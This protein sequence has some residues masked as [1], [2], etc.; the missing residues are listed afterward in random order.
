MIFNLGGESG[1]RGSLYIWVFDDVLLVAVRW[2]DTSVSCVSE[3]PEVTICINETSVHGSNPCPK[4]IFIMVR[5]IN[6]SFYAIKAER[7]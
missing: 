4:F 6:I 1:K 3:I 2:M 7:K 5:I